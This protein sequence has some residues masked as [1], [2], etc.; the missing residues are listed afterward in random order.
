MADQ[1]RRGLLDPTLFDKL[2]ADHAMLGGRGEEIEDLEDRRDAMRF[3][4]VPHIERFNEA[5]LRSTVKR[6]LAWILNTTNLAS[7]TDLDPY[8][9]V[10]T[11]V[12]NYGVEEL[13]G[14]AITNRLVLKRAQDIRSAIHAFEPRIDKSSLDVSV[15][16]K[17]E[18]ENAITFVIHADVTSALRAMPVRFHTD[19][20]ID[21]AIA[22]VRE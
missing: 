13:S 5:A 4:T 2:V 14:K 3:Y 15:V 6:E 11:S 7:A 21:T 16:E 12:L 17:T 1:R 20:E 22:T 18:R 19:V 10:K 8:P 9:E